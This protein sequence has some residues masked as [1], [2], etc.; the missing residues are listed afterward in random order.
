MLGVERSRKDAARYRGFGQ[1]LSRGS[2]PQPRPQA[3]QVDGEEFAA[4]GRHGKRGLTV[5]PLRQTG[6]EIRDPLPQCQEIDVEGSVFGL[7]QVSQGLLEPGAG[8]V[9][10]GKQR[11]P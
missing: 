1:A 9:G 6:S 3:A 5:R 7:F 2:R 8:G 11:G 10:L 4:W